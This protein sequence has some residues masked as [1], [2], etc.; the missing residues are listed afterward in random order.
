MSYPFKNQ[1]LPLKA[2][3]A[4]LLSRLSVEEKAGMLSFN[5]KAVPRLG[6][7]EWNIGTE[8]ARGYVTKVS[9]DISTVFP[10]PIGMASMFDP[11]MMFRIGE[12]AGDEARY[13]YEK[14]KNGGLMLFGPTVD[15][16]R[17]PRWGRNE[18]GYGEDPFLTGEMTKQYT[19]GLAGEIPHGDDVYLKTIPILKHFCCNNNE[20]DRAV[21]NANV[22][23]RTLHEYYY[24][25]FK[26]ALTDGGAKA[27]MTAYNKLSGVPA[28]M[29]PDVRHLLKDKWGVYFSVSDLWDFK[30]CV[31]DNQYV[32]THAEALALCL[33][34][35]ADSMTD[36]CGMV[37]AAVTDALERGLI[38]EAD[39]DN[40][41][42]NVLACRFR[43]GEFDESHPYKKIN[44]KPEGEA[45]R[46]VNL[47]AAQKQI[48]LLKNNGLLP[49]K[50]GVK[51]AL[52]GPLADE[53]YR[54]WYTGVSSYGV[55]VRDGIGLEFGEENVSF[56]NCFDIVTL[57]SERNGKYL[58]VDESGEYVLRAYSEHP[59]KTAQFEYHEWGE[60]EV[61]LKSVQNGLYAIEE[62]GLYKAKSA[63]PYDWFI[64]EWFK[65][66]I[67]GGLHC[68]KSWHDKHFNAVSYKA[69]DIYIDEQ[70]DY[71]LK[72]KP[73]HRRAAPEK[74]F[75][76]EI[77]S[78]GTERAAA[79]A[80]EA[81]VVI[82]CAGNHPMQIAR[83]GL[84]RGG[85]GLP[86]SQSALVRAA[87][88]AN[89]NTVLLMV[90]SY[91][92]AVNW[93]DENLPALLYT[94]HAGAELGNAV[95]QT[96]SGKNNPAARCPQT[97]YQSESQLPDFTD[98][99]IT[100][101]DSTYMYYDEQPLYPFGH[102]L[103]YSKFDYSDF[104]VDFRDGKLTELAVNYKD[105][106][107]FANVSVKNESNLDGDEVVQ[108]YY[109]A[110]SPRVK[111]P[112]RKLCGF[113]R[114]KVKAGEAVK[115]R[116]EIPYNSLEFYDVTR[117]KLCVEKGAYEFT[118]GAS[119]LDIRAAAT[120]EIDGETIPP[121]D[122]SKTVK[123]KNYDEK[124]VTELD[125]SI[126][127]NDWYAAATGSWGGTL[128]FNCADLKNYEYAEI[129]A[130]APHKQTTVDIFAGS[131]NGEHL[132]SAALNPAPSKDSFT[133][134]KIPLKKHCGITPL[135]LRLNG[136]ASIYS[137]KFV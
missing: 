116:I 14:Y 72:I 3:V 70:A 41:V 90:A 103:S 77:I 76:A 136:I 47:E 109:R 17:D 105:C 98:Y 42:G 119:C 55:T 53:I 83:E 35:G 43:L 56:D 32:K 11:E 12:V 96:L 87:Y 118:V 13:Y 62:D 26:P 91:P 110:V 74:Q 125:F 85:L 88:E 57:K 18:E 21:C 102:G 93:E 101:N 73:A 117:E 27:V 46:K 104:S 68:F 113:K 44:A 6:I 28:I 8:I 132:A 114:V 19:K 129:F 71:A 50:K 131:V 34:N 137:L 36:D 24:Q 30:E 33:K 121:R 123:A 23:P 54:D 108:I 48:C 78:K 45:A 130:C 64:K 92:Y 97:W 120:V 1:S 115:V 111:R 49:L 22:E 112:L 52:I 94:S 65:P 86:R 126:P 58:A 5:V 20:K 95:A 4:D 81:D 99:D 135:V 124:D 89:P 15:M 2:R 100:E 122:M 75:K 9:E 59:G 128:T 10:Q 38:T 63:T 7:G 66:E 80:R 61:N 29:N 51:I 133:Y 69:M 25:A 79:L 37:A 40:A 16:E 82:V 60:N 84:D 67:Q 134:Y 106:K 107:I 127:L 39:L 31:L